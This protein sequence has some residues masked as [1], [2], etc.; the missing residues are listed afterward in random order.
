[1]KAGI[2]RYTEC[3]WRINRLLIEQYKL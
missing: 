1:M 3:G 2:H